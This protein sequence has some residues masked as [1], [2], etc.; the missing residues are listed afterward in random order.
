MSDFERI[1][2]LL[3]VP[4]TLDPD[5]LLFEGIDTSHYP[6]FSVGEVAKIFFARSPSWLRDA[7]RAGQLTMPGVD[8][9]GPKRRIAKSARFF[10]LEDIE[11]VDHCLMYHQLIPSYKFIA[12]LKILQCM[13]Q[14]WGYF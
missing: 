8:F 12:A 11:K 3:V 5:K 10:C 13:G 2:P 4:E 6:C 1:T 9:D 7:E 14:I